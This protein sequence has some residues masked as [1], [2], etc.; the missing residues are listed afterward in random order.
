MKRE[1]RAE[2]LP[3]LGIEDIIRSWSTSSVGEGLLH[4]LIIYSTVA[5]NSGGADKG[6]RIWYC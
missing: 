4:I 2:H 6:G 3:S 1:G 5:L